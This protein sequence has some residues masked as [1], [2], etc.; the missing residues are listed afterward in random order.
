MCDSVRLLYLLTY[1]N[2]ES[3]TRHGTNECNQIPLWLIPNSNKKTLLLLESAQLS[4][5]SRL[6]GLGPAG[7]IAEEAC[8]LGGRRRLL[9]D[10]WLYESGGWWLGLGLVL[11][12]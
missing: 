11:R 9:I 4:H 7:S 6:L 12:G 3:R 10:G 2:A 5:A 1:L 8:R